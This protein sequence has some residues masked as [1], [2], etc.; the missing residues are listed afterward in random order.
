MS[1]EPKIIPA[2]VV[3]A[4]SASMMA[5]SDLPIPTA[6]EKLMARANALVHALKERTDNGGVHLEVRANDGMEYVVMVVTAKARAAEL[7]TGV[8][9]RDSGRKMREALEYLCQIGERCDVKATA[10]RGLGR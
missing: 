8:A 2:P 1:T 4:K 9:W 10:A 3:A 7:D 6:D 5:S